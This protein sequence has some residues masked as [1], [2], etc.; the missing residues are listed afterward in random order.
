MILQRELSAVGRWVIC[1]GD[2]KP[3]AGDW[4]K[5]A[6]RHETE[7]ELVQEVPVHQLAITSGVHRRAPGSSHP[8]VVALRT[9]SLCYV[10]S[11]CHRSN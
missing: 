9:G 5:A 10:L 11:Q 1:L 2:E 8:G 3:S 6:G 4:Y 7:E